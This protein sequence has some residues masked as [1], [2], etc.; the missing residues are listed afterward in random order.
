MCHNKRKPTGGDKGQHSW[1]TS[2]FQ[3][4]LCT[5][6]SMIYSFQFKKKIKKGYI[7]NSVS[8]F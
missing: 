4:R 6:R 7:F 3:V 8:I 5:S 1:A 2:G